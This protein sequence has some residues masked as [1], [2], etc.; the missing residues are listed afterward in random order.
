MRLTEVSIDSYRTISTEQHLVTDPCIT[1]L[2]GSNES[3]KTNILQAI[4][5]IDPTL[6]LQREDISKCNRERCSQKKLPCLH[7]TFDI[8]EDESK[9]LAEISPEFIEAHQ[10]I[11]KEMETLFLSF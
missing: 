4:N 3:G 11:L 8:S 5:C 2:I 7:F 9:H 10:F 6:P 1:T